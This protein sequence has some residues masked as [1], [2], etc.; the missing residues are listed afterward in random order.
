[1][2]DASL[3]GHGL[4]P[5][6]LIFG[7]FAIPGRDQMLGFVQKHRAQSQ[8]PK[9][10]LIHITH[11]RV[12][13][14]PGGCLASSS[15]FLDEMFSSSY[16][17]FDVPI[18]GGFSQECQPFLIEIGAVEQFSIGGASIDQECPLGFCPFNSGFGVFNR[19]VMTS[20][21][22]DF[23]T[24]LGPQTTTNTTSAGS[25]TVSNTCVRTWSSR[26]CHTA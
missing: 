6:E 2:Q 13:G 25:Q 7:L 10:F 12:I 5:I 18:K 21:S 8:S 20:A 9:F 22:F 26:G 4:D 3:Y 23:P 14:I 1:M 11:F 24:P 19:L 16:I 17:H 15:L